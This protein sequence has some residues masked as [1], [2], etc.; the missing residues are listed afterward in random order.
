MGGAGLPPPDIGIGSD[1]EYDDSH[2][3]ECK[4]RFNGQI[5]HRDIVVAKLA[6]HALGAEQRSFAIIWLEDP[7]VGKNAEIREII[8]VNNGSA[9][10][11]LLKVLGQKIDK[12]KGLH[13]LKIDNIAPLIN[14]NIYNELKAARSIVVE[15]ASSHIIT[16]NL[17]SEVEFI[18]DKLRSVGTSGKVP[19]PT[20]LNSY[21]VFPRDSDGHNYLGS[22]QKAKRP[23]LDRLRDNHSGQF[24]K[25]D[26]SKHAIASK[27]ANHV[28]AELICAKV[29]RQDETDLHLALHG[30]ISQKV[31]QYLSGDW[32]DRAGTSRN[33]ANDK[34]SYDLL[35]NDGK[36]GSDL[37]NL[38]KNIVTLDLVLLCEESLKRRVETEERAAVFKVVLS[39]VDDKTIYKWMRALSSKN[40]IK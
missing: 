7:A 33:L 38:W 1:P 15:L 9:E 8:A 37:I 30:N 23:E 40:P 13:R 4:I 2:S 35:K 20:K 6:T 11:F 31:Q 17:I 18:V 26:H 29:L 32:K 25:A 36:S 28:V 12:N 16:D 24:N 19:N 3:F 34:L 21:K 10:E 22:V 14:R 27:F 39:I 5:Y